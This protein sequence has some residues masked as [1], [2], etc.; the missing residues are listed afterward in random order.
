[1]LLRPIALATALLA[2]SIASADDVRPPEGTAVDATVGTDPAKLFDAVVDAYYAAMSDTPICAARGCKPAIVHKAAFKDGVVELGK[3]S[4]DYG[5]VYA[6]LVGDGHGSWFA[7]SPI[8]DTFLI[9][10]CGAG[11][12]IDARVTG[13][14]AKLASGILWITV[15][16]EARWYLT[17]ARKK[18]DFDGYVWLYACRIGPA[19]K[20]AAIKAGGSGLPGSVKIAGDHATV[21]DMNGTHTV[22]VT[23]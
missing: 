9:A 15:D 4:G 11:H 10:D 6:L 23:F 7:P 14:K 16:A 18:G 22:T 1:M 21:E 5:D 20:C 19:P 17:D 12:C 13:L 2:S 8:D 3:A